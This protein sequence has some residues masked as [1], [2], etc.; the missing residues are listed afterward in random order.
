VLPFVGDLDGSKIHVQAPT[1]VVFL[2]GGQVTDLSVKVPK[3][4]RDAFLKIIDNPALK[5]RDLIQAEE[6]T[7]QI[8]FNAH[9]QDLLLFET[10]LAQITELILLFCESEGSLAELGAFSMVPDIAARL[11]VVIRDKYW[12]SDSF[13]KL[14]PLKALENKHG[15]SAICVVD[16]LDIGMSGKS[17]ESVKIDI[18]KDR[19][20]EPIQLRMEKTREP[21][22]FNSERSGHVI[23]LIVG[24]IQEYGALTVEEIALILK[25]LAVVRSDGEIRA[26]LLCAAAVKWVVEK[27]KGIRTYYIA[28]NVRDAASITWN[29]GTDV[30]NKARRRLLIREHWKKRDELRLRGIVEVYGGAPA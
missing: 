11:L 26:Y 5:G 22:T 13:V 29:G 30:K 4:L 15:E 27:K 14:G 20:R 9:Y 10:D 24:L 12:T 16:D 2:C 28:H 25:Q 1:D 19:L 7:G 21:S 18:L 6:I 17:A 3:S 23:K 8:N